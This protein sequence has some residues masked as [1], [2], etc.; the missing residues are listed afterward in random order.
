VYLTKFCFEQNGGIAGCFCQQHM[1]PNSSLE[2]A[3]RTH[4]ASALGYYHHLLCRLQS[5]FDLS[6]AMCVDFYYVP[7]SKTRK[8]CDTFSDACYLPECGKVCKEIL[9]I[10]EGVSM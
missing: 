8:Y 1:V 4:L 3:F 7:E 2:N 10:K 6:L 5:E 9:L